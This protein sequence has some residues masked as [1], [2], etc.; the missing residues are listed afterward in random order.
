[1]LLL[2]QRPET[3]DI[4][5][6]LEKFAKY[7]EGS[8]VATKSARSIGELV[9]SGLTVPYVSKGCYMP[10]DPSK[11]ELT[12]DSRFRYESQS[13]IYAALL[14]LRPDIDK[15]FLKAAV[16]GLTDEQLTDIS[17]HAFTGHNHHEPMHPAFDIRG[18]AFTYETSLAYLR[19]IN[20]HRSFGRQVLWFGAED[21]PMSIIGK[22][23]NDNYAL[24]HA[25]YWQSHEQHFRRRLDDI[26]SDICNLTDMVISRYGTEAGNS[27]LTHIL[28]LGAQ[29]TMVLSAPISQWNYMTSLR[30]G[31]GGDFGYRKDV[32]E[33]LNILRQTDPGLAGMAGHLTEPNVNDPVQI[34]GRS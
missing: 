20:R 25:E 24:S 14:G 12:R 10:N 2:D 32:W 13:S 5:L 4:A 8:D 1:M 3:A 7:A 22:G 15:E 18:T 6:H 26:F 11:V 21:K 23:F 19:D 30:V 17:F 34:L 27:L 29:M 31:M 9:L 16:A 33:M 28:P